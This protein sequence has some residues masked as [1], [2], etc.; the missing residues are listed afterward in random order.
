L[1]F[2]RRDNLGGYEGGDFQ[3]HM[4]DLSGLDATKLYYLEFADNVNASWGLTKIDAIRLVDQNEFNSVVA[5]DR[6]VMIS[7][8]ETTFNYTL[9][10]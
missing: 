2:D 7:G 5:S 4:L 9:P 8:I 6:A 1:R 3:N 10:Y